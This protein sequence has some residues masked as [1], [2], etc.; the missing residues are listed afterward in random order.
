MKNWF[1]F[2]CHKKFEP[3]FLNRPLRNVV[4]SFFFPSLFVWWFF[5]PGPT[6][7]A[8]K[9]FSFVN[10]R[11]LYVHCYDCVVSVSW[12]WITTESSGVQFAGQF[13]NANKNTQHVRVMNTWI[14]ELHC[15]CDLYRFFALRFQLL[16]KFLGINQG[17][18]DTRGVHTFSDHWTLSHRHTKCWFRKYAILNLSC[19]L[20]V[21]MGIVVRWTFLLLWLLFYPFL[22]R[23]IPNPL[24]I[25][26]YH[27]KLEIQFFDIQ[28]SSYESVYTTHTKY[29]L[30][31][32]PRHIS[33]IARPK[34]KTFHMGLRD[35]WIHRGYYCLS[36]VFFIRTLRHVL[37]FSHSHHRAPRQ[38][39][40]RW[41]V[42]ILQAI[43]LLWWAWSSKG[44][45]GPVKLAKFSH[46]T[47][48]T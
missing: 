37:Q 32:T 48:H 1:K 5:F 17:D 7:I 8:R 25:R 3:S 29:T 12:N 15:R 35:F 39:A 40:L 14:S 6:I 43:Y 22:L 34:R 13:A 47:C 18:D 46:S 36:T 38:S 26:Q 20:K 42:W 24:R 23:L 27:R 45:L 30:A 28:S 9:S 21:R 2:F 4:F 33:V 16:F 44:W 11:F 10:F 19:P 31:V 41:S